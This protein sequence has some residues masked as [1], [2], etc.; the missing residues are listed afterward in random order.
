MMNKFLDKYFGKVS[1][2]DLARIIEDLCVNHMAY[3]NAFVEIKE[4]L[5]ENPEIIKY[6]NFQK[7]EN[8]KQYCFK[9]YTYLLNKKK[10]FENG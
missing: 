5:S 6:V 9:I 10:E 3:R 8:S 2:Q 1:K 7:I 4:I